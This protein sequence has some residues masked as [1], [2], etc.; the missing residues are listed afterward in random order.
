MVYNP[1]M[2]SSERNKNEIGSPYRISPKV[3]SE[4]QSGTGEKMHTEGHEAL[5]VMTT[6]GSEELGRVMAEKLI[7]EGLA[8]CVSILPSVTSCYRWEGKVQ[9]EDEILL[10]IK[11]VASRFTAVKERIISLHNYQC[12]EIIGIPVSGGHEPYLEWLRKETQL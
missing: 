8:A 10:L 6:V 11:T 12:P 7:G 5:I 1:V 4:I 9:M 3:L 2:P